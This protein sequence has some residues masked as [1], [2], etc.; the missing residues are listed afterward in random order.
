MKILSKIEFVR[1][2]KEYIET[3]FLKIYNFIE[4]NDEINLRSDKESFR[5]EV[6][7]YLYNIY[8]DGESNRL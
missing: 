5:L 8:V 1:K 3:V 6:I 2:N 4:N 7:N